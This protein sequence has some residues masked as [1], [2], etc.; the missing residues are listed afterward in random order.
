MRETIFA[1]FDGARIVADSKL[2]LP[3]NTRV[4]VIVETM[5]EVSESVYPDVDWFEQYDEYLWP[6]H[7]HP[8][9]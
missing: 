8:V 1:T 2:N 3:S 4:R 9:H 5:E 7:D 6:R